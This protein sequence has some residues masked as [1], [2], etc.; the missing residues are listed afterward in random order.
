M[1]RVEK[2]PNELHIALNLEQTE[3]KMGHITPKNWRSALA[4][5]ERATGEGH[6]SFDWFVASILEAKER[7]CDE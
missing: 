6:R 2:M 1:T 3:C 5:L 7:K 4:S